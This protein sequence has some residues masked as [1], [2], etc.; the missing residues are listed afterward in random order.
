[1]IITLFPR[2]CMLRSRRFLAAAAKPGQENVD[3]NVPAMRA[4]RNQ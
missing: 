2:R 4:D 1:M 3:T